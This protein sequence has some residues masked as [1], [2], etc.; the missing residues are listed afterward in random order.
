[1]DTIA[2]TR[3]VIRD[4]EALQDF[5]EAM[6]EHA[7][8]TELEL[9]RLRK[10]PG[11]HDA[12]STLFRAIHNIKGDAMLCRFNT[13]KAIAH[14]IESLLARLRADEIVFSDVLAEVI[15]LAID[16]LEL[17]TEATLAGKTLDHLKLI[18]LV[19]G[20]ERLASLS[21]ETLE[22][23]CATVIEATTGFRPATAQP[24]ITADKTATTVSAERQTDLDFFRALALQLD[25]RSPMLKGRSIRVSRLALQTNEIAGQPIAPAQLEAA[26]L[27]HDIGMMLVPDALWLKVGQLSAEERASIREHPRYGAGLLE[28]MAGWE[29]AARIVNEHHEMP[30]GK[31]YPAGLRATDICP[32]AKLLAIIDAFESVILKQAHRGRS[33]SFLRAVAEINANPNQFAPE[34]IAPFNR[35]IRGILERS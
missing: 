22:Q 17:A 3:P 19:G 13:A 26:A 16:R 23:E 29:D 25:A 31:G 28:R 34:W 12:V 11:D 27:M 5:A 33:R 35:V 30:D 2:L 21:G 1:M 10:S 4:R 7:L 14:P 18:A 9:G 32:G 20:L 8:T 6:N 15:L 24:L